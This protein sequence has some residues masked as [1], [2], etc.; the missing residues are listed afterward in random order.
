M[1]SR[2]LHA[3]AD[4]GFKSTQPLPKLLNE[5]AKLE[6][7]SMKVVENILTSSRSIKQ[8]LSVLSPI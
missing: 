8:Y 4:V 7:S 3:V 6:M 5:D 2:K 1:I